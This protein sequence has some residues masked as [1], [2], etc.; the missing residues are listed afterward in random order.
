MIDIFWPCSFS[1]KIVLAAATSFLL[2]LL[3][4]P[5]FIRKLLEL[6]IG[7]PIRTYEG[8]L[9][10]ELHKKK[11]NTPTMGGGLIIF[12]VLISML[13]WA[14]WSSLFTPLLCS[15]MIVFGA[16]GAL[17]DWAKFSK[18]SF[19]GIPGRLRFLVQTL[20]ALFVIVLLFFPSLFELVGIQQ[21]ALLHQGRSVEWREF[22]ATTF[23][24]FMKS[25][26]CIASGITWAFVFFIQWFTIVGTANAVNLTDGLDGL[27]SG[28]SI[29]VAIPLILISCISNH[30]ELSY[31]YAFPY[32]ESS[33]QIALCLSALIGA[34]I[35]FLWFNSYPA[36]VFM[37]DTGSLAIG[38]LLGTSAVL[39][40]QEWLLALIAGIFVDET[41]S[42]MIQ[43]LYF[44]KTR[45]RIFLCSPLHH[46]FEYK[47]L[48]E[49]KVVIRFWIVGLLFSILGILSVL[50]GRE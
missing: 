39:L 31:Q 36:Q 32:I 16:L 50:I 38:G 5:P 9:L 7:Q 12:S 6:K 22:L 49:S 10:T 14:D 48:A 33:G 29:L 35:G 47:G 4:G 46:H 43:V 42:V 24:P 30:Q 23:L 44:K 28:C 21:S 2:S 3:L 26:I 37:G 13:F 8:F 40:R 11:E 27:A 25:P 41:L 34:S 17:D 15:T 19:K 45:K 20:W 18:K 1:T